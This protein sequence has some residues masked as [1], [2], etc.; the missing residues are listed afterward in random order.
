LELQNITDV[1]SHVIYG[2]FLTGG[3]AQQL[4]QEIN[5]AGSEHSK[6][7]D[8]Q[9]LSAGASFSEVLE[10]VKGIIRTRGEIR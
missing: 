1:N 7:D 10:A 2:Q 3:A 9:S 4:W 6:S 8:F 5:D